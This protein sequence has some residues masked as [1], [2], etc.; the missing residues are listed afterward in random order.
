[1]RNCIEETILEFKYGVLLKELGE[2]YKGNGGI[3][4]EIEGELL[5]ETELQNRTIDFGAF[6]DDNLMT[7]HYDMQIHYQDVRNYITYNGS[8][9]L[10]ILEKIKKKLNT[11]IALRER[12]SIEHNFQWQEQRKRKKERG[13][14]K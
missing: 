10:E 5:C 9:K 8:D 14:V 6:A 2:C 3:G 4:S 11:D 12:E 1:M 7:N 13:K